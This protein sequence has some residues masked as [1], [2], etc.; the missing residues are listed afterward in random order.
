MMPIQGNGADEKVMGVPGDPPSEEDLKQIAGDVEGL[1]FRNDAARE[2]FHQQMRLF[3]EQLAEHKRREE[4]MYR[5]QEQSYQR[6]RADQRFQDRE[7]GPPV[8]G[9][10]W[11]EDFVPGN[12]PVS[13][14]LS[15]WA[16]P[17]EIEP[18]HPL[19]EPGG[20]TQGVTPSSEEEVLPVDYALLALIHDRTWPDCVPIWN[21][22]WPFVMEAAVSDGF[23]GCE[24][25]SLSRVNRALKHVEADLVKHQGQ[26]DA[27]KEETDWR[28]VQ[29]RL[30]NLRNEGKPYTTQE[31]LGHRMGCCK[32]TVNKAIKN[33]STLTGW[34]A[35]YRKKSPKAQSLNEVV[36]DQTP[37]ERER[38]PADVLPADEV[39]DV[40]SK[41]IQ[42]AT[43]PEERAKL[44]ALGQDERRKMAEVCSEHFK[45]PEYEPP[46]LS[47]GK[48]KPVKLLGRKP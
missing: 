37:N 30:L 43:T 7:A 47:D 36:M 39:D 40:M 12:D 17:H 5:E 24:G 41:L 9:L 6:I 25:Y 26:G 23:R 16:P 33:S 22:E 4:Q 19:W 2:R 11:R 13:D 10:V 45:D 35:R 20:F 3:H 28:D 18:P 14:P 21:G 48:R 42:E 27:A 44:N 46:D 15:G 32:T 8:E 31:D 1:V 34:M 38:D 29:D